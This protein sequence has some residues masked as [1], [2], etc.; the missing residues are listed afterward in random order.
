[1][2]VFLSAMFASSFLLFAAPFV[3]AISPWLLYKLLN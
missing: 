1:M 2:I 3:V